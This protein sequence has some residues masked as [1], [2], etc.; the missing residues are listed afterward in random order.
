[1]ARYLAS[2]DQGARTRPRPERSTHTRG[3]ARLAMTPASH[4]A[5]DAT[6]DHNVVLA[7]GRAVAIGG[8]PPRVG[9]VVDTRIVNGSLQA[10]VFLDAST[11]LWLPAT[12][13]T[14]LGDAELEVVDHSEFL[15]R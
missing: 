10:E 13:L 4:R 12:Q 15:V 3:S 1:M 11:R 14:P 6:A 7:K 9:T 5:Q 2:Y 8:A